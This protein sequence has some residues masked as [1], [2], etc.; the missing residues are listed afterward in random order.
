MN[1]KN[2][3][4]KNAIFG[5]FRSNNHSQPKFAFQTVPSGP[6]AKKTKQGKTAVYMPSYH[7]QK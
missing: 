5:N 2:E 6:V 3:K 1:R 4:Y 7:G